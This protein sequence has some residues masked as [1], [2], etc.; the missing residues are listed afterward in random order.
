MNK[1]IFIYLQNKEQLSLV[2]PIVSD[3]PNY[4]YGIIIEDINIDDFLRTPT[5]KLSNIQFVEIKNWNIASLSSYG[6]FISTDTSINNGS[7][8]LMILINMFSVLNVPIFELQE[9]MFPLSCKAS[10]LATHYLSW[11]DNKRPNSTII[12]YPISSN[13]QSVSDG[14]YILVITDLYHD[15]YT[16]QDINN[17]FSA[18]Y[19]YA[20]LHTGAA[21]IWKMAGEEMSNAEI[22]RVYNN[23]NA[24]YA[25]ELNKICL[26]NSHTMLS[27]L[28]ITE[29][30]AKAKIVITTITMPRLLDCELYGK[31][32]AIYSSNANIINENIDTRKTTIFHN[33]EELEQVIFDTPCKTLH[34]G[35]LHHYNN[36]AFISVMDD[37]YKK[38]SIIPKEYMESLLLSYMLLD[39]QVAA[40]QIC[41]S[42]NSNIRT[43]T[44]EI[45]KLKE[46]YRK[47]LKAIRRM[48][49]SL[50]IEL[51]II[52]VLLILILFM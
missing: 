50:G 23:Y 15:C 34:T 37:L 8:I 27:R 49:I 25:K 6:A 44:L 32:V 38:D 43:P 47:H 48:A 26:C 11:Y 3:N 14:E 17:F 51:I 40:T 21:I 24:F 33:A 10:S 42:D 28:D 2:Y 52:I 41:K 16:G 46:K 9:R 18:I 35:L 5:G 29:L 39:K 22:T 20:R 36:D 7:N 4:E 45:E 30:I 31:P 13:K 1:R 19:E 12:G